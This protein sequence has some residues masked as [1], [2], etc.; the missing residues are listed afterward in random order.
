MVF[1]IV[2]M[3]IEYFVLLLSFT[4]VLAHVMNEH[5]HVNAVLAMVESFVQHCLMGILCLS[6]VFLPLV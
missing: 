5:I 4:V 2:L 1:M 6:T 3:A